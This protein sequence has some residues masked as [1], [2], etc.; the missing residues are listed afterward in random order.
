MKHLDGKKVME[1]RLGGPVVAV[2]AD[3][4][5]LPVALNPETKSMVLHLAYP[6]AVTIAKPKVASS[7]AELLTPS[8]AQLLARQGL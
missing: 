2:S 6:G 4:T 8:L 3:A 5:P 1:L 7:F